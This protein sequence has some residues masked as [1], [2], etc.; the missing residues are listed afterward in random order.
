MAVFRPPTDD[1]H[2]FSD[3]SNDTPW[4][5][6]KRLAFNFL[7]HYSG[8]PKGRN[9]YKLSDGTYV[10]SKPAN[11]SMIVRTYQGGHDHEIDAEE[12]T[13]LTGAGYGDY[14]EGS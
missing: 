10:E 1:L 14:I 6:E 5:E 9:V 13:S 12:V 4:N 11:I 8:N 7:R 2:Y 3:F